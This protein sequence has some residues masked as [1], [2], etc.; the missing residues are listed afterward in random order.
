MKKSTQK[1]NHSKDENE[2]EDHENQKLVTRGN[3]TVP[4][5]DATKASANC[6]RSNTTVTPTPTPTDVS[7]SIVLDLANFSPFKEENPQKPLKFGSVVNVFKAVRLFKEKVNKNDDDK[8]MVNNNDNN[9]ES[10]D[11]GNGGGNNDDN[12]ANDDNGGNDRNN[13]RFGQY[14]LKLHHSMFCITV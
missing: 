14:I 6:R 1:A 5:S 2:N 12:E 7:N 4:K 11:Q 9:N 10:D 13:I 8:K 3:K